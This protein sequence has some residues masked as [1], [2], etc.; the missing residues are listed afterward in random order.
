MRTVAIAAI[1]RPPR[2]PADFAAFFAGMLRRSLPKPPQRPRPIE[3]LSDH[4][5]ADLG[6]RP[7]GPARD[8]RW[9]VGEQ[10]RFEAHHASEF[11]YAYYAPLQ[12]R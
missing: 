3:G 2:A 6:L 10:A 9:L 1:A 11:D 4:M 5:L 8:S 12:R 7:V